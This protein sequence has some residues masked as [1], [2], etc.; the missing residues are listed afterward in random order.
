[1][2]HIKTLYRD[3]VGYTILLINLSV[4]QVSFELKSFS[5]LQYVNNSSRKFLGTRSKT[6]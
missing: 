1:M 4:Q 5:K 2:N 6:I 3:I